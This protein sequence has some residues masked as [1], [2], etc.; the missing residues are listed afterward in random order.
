MS[1]KYFIEEQRREEAKEARV[2]LQVQYTADLDIQL[3][4]SS[5][6]YPS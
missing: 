6:K 1:K 3:Q 2:A 5:K 4:V